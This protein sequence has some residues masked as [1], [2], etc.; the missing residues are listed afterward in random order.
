M[1]V[2]CAA[3]ARSARQI[4]ESQDIDL[5][6]IDIVLAHEGGL[7]VARHAV[8][9]GARV[10]LMSGFSDA[11][12]I[13][14]PFPFIAKPFNMRELVDIAMFLAGGVAAD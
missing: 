6:L 2:S 9:R 3:D 10:L 4:L 1:D 14:L 12:G 8:R 13:D 11:A 5:A 7:G